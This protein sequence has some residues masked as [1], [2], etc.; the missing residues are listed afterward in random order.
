MGTLCLIHL[1]LFF[2]TLASFLGFNESLIASR[3][4]CGRQKVPFELWIA[5]ERF[6][7][8]FLLGMA[9]KSAPQLRLLWLW[10]PLPS[11]FSIWPFQVKSFED[12]GQASCCSPNAVAVYFIFELM[13]QFSVLEELCCLG[14]ADDHVTLLYWRKAF[15]FSCN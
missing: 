7:E 13:G 2:I 9:F 4:I 8:L 6:L 3:S 10:L 5:V 15:F 11:L 1:N 14:R 12:S